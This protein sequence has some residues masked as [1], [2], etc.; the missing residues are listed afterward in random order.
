[1]VFKGTTGAYKRICLFNSRWIAEKEKY[2]K[3]IIPAEFYHLLIS[4]P[5]RSLIRVQRRSEN[6]VWILEARSE[7]E[8]G[9][10]YILV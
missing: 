1:M 7:N 2:P 6:G 5:V 4:L 10:W 3:Y 9:K 8:C